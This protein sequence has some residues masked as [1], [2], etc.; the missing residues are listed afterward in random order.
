MSIRLYVFNDEANRPATIEEIERLFLNCHN[1]GTGTAD[2]D[3]MMSNGVAKDPSHVGF[4]VR[5]QDGA[6]S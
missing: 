6:Q 3:Y 4:T 5:I 2:I 1:E